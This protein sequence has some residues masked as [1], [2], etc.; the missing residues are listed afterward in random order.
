MSV[1][2]IPI[3]AVLGNHRLLSPQARRGVPDAH[4]CGRRECSTAKL[5]EIGGAGSRGVKASGRLRRGT[6]AAGGWGETGVKALRAGGD[7]R[8]LEAGGALW[9]GCARP[10]V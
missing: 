1:V 2:R 7:R 9:P 8:I 5:P 4:G 3:V 10:S 6:L